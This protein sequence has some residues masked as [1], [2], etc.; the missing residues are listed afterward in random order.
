MRLSPARRAL[1]GLAVAA[2]LLG[3]LMLFAGI[4]RVKVLLF[5]ITVHIPMPTWEDGTLWLFAGFVTVNLLI[6]MEVADRLSLKGDLEI[7]RD[8]QLAMLPGG[9]HTP[10]T[11][12]SAA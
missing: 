7:A 6:L 4:H 1:Y 10:A 12:P 5:P 2:A 3:M 8:I 9:I 11:R